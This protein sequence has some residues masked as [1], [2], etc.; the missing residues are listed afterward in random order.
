MVCGFCVLAESSAEP[1]FIGEQPMLP[2]WK[3]NPTADF[4]ILTLYPLPV[5]DLLITAGSF[6]V[7]SFEFSM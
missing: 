2:C 1:G 3:W 6:S 5:L 4:G 7:D